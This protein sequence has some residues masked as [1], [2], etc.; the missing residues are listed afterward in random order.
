MEYS[1]TTERTKVTYYS[2]ETPQKKYAEKSQS[3]EAT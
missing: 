2:M 3:Q 1:S